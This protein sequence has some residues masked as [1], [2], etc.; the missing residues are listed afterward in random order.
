MNDS[1]VALRM[2]R[3]NCNTGELHATLIWND[4]ADLDLHVITPSGEHMFWS[5]PESECGGWLDRDMN[6]GSYSLEPIENIFWASAP[7]GR[8]KI[9][10]HNFNNRTD[11][12]TV[13]T[14]PNRKVPFRVRLVKNDTTEWFEGEC[15]A[16]EEVNCFEFDFNG[17]GAVGPF[18]VIPPS[19]TPN[20]FSE[21]CSKNNVTYN[22]GKCYY[23]LKKT[24]NISEKKDMVLHDE[25]SDTFTI[26]AVPCREA[27]N[28]PVNEKIRI[29]PSDIPQG[30]RLFVQSTSHNRKIPKDTHTL[31]RVP[32]R[33]A[34]K[35][36]MSDRYN[37]S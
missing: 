9:Y 29:K 21:L 30:K 27:L 34:L 11:D 28:F 2:K 16:R 23:A 1:V 8:Y 33:E 19:D 22:P 26:G 12:K 7:S 24:E 32:I 37:F 36:R 25:I 4:I 18:I 31:A 5:H 20:T 17:S 13:F 35:Y 3:E 14:D 15:G 10:V 6:A